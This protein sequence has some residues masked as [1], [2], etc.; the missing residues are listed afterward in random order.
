MELIEDGLK[1]AGEEPMALERANHLPIP[2]TDCQFEWDRTR[3]EDLPFPARQV[4]RGDGPVRFKEGARIP[5]RGDDLAEAIGHGGDRR[6]HHPPELR[7]GGQGT[8]P[9][10]PRY[11]DEGTLDL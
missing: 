8:P 4:R 10:G 1:P 3:C 6:P 7:K 2:A 5:E 11:A 9:G